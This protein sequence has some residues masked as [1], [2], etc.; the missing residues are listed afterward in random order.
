MITI[1]F[2]LAVANLG[3]G[4]ALAVVL[5]RLPVWSTAHLDRGARLESAVG[6]DAGAVDDDGSAMAPNDEWSQRLK[7][8]QV[9]P[10]SAIERLLWIVKLET[11]SRRERLIELDRVFFDPSTPQ[12][13]KSELIQEL[14]SCHQLLDSWID[15]VAPLKDQVGPLAESLEEL[16]LD[17]AFNLRSCSEALAETDRDDVARQLAAAMAAVN[18]LRDRVDAHLCQLLTYEDRLKSIPDRYRTFGTFDTLTHLGLAGVFDEWRASDP[19]HVRLVSLV[20]LDL[21]RFAPFTQQIG[22]ARGDVALLRFGD[23]LRDLVRKDRGFDRVA[24]FSGQRF[25]MFLGDTSAK[26]AS[27]GAERIRQT[28]EATSFKLGDATSEVTASVAVIEIGKTEGPDEFIERLEATLDECKKAGRNCGFVDFGG[29]PELICLPQ[30][31]VSVRV[32]ELD[33]EAGQ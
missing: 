21:D 8:A 16:L 4:F 22:A 2:A 33:E 25:I 12:L 24:R 32:I 26:N 30:Y 18:V 17:Q 3:L 31:Q 29:G 23:M 11:A 1:V 6:P 7:V 13:I 19:D 28:I 10:K 27:K 15:Q 20:M 5:D 9:V 14:A